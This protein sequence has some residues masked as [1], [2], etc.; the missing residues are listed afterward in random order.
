MSPSIIILTGPPGSGKTVI[1]DLLA[2]DAPQK[3]VHLRADFFFDWI[4][5][6]FIPPYEKTSQQ[7]N[8]T[9]LTA[10][11][12]SA[13]AYWRGDYEV[14]VDG[15]IGPWFL[16]LFQ[17]AFGK[18]FAPVSY[19]IVRAGEQI[20]VERCLDRDRKQAELQMDAIRGLHSSF[21]N[22][23]KFE[24]N[25]VDTSVMLPE[26]AAREIRNALASGRFR[27]PAA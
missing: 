2:K 16:P 25:V 17:T 15:I 27:L 22:V 21:A 7:Q 1:A 5:K 12:M 24:P 9:V 20:A 3:S 10:I 4:R 6:G 11:A 8:T 13:L 26:D 23:G 14:I 18:A 19:V